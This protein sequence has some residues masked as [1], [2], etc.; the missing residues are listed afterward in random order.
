[1]KEE[2]MD[3]IKKI[4]EEILSCEF[5]NPTAEAEEILQTI[6]N[7]S[8]EEKVRLLSY[9]IQNCGLIYKIKEKKGGGISREQFVTLAENLGAEIIHKL[10]EISEILNPPPD[11]A[12]CKLLEILKRYFDREKKIVILTF[13]IHT[14]F[15]PYI[16]RPNALKLDDYQFATLIKKHWRE[17]TLTAALYRKE[18]NQKTERASEILRILE[19]IPNFEARAVVLMCL[20]DVI[21]KLTLETFTKAVEEGSKKLIIDIIKKI[22]TNFDSANEDKKEKI[23]N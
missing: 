11:Q 5:E 22:Q 2:K 9:F 16:Y 7:E 12:A 23:I 20:I 15:T 3:K 10:H 13:V 6:E 14:P 18:F 8:E 21:E 1:M 19:N 17:I 4:K